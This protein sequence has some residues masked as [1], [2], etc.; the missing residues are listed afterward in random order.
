MRTDLRGVSL[1]RADP[2]LIVPIMPAESAG[3]VQ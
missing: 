3:N 1:N 2:P